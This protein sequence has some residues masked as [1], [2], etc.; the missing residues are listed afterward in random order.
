MQS[1]LQIYVLWNFCKLSVSL[2]NANIN[3]FHLIIKSKY[4]I[5]CRCPFCDFLQIV[6]N[7]ICMMHI[8]TNNGITI[9]ESSV[10]RLPK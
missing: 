8:H 1:V 6:L 7:R 9:F 5:V 3:I 2:I 10:A 4:L